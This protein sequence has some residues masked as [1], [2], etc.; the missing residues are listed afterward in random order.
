MDD[1][2]SAQGRRDY[3]LTVNGWVVQ[4]ATE[5]EKP[6][7]EEAR[8]LGAD[9]AA[10]HPAAAGDEGVYAE[11]EAVYRESEQAR[12]R[13]GLVG[14][15]VDGVMTPEAAVFEAAWIVGALRQR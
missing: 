14:P 4:A 8:R 9:W 5:A 15:E 13:R 10:K 1:T 11:L 7:V 3:E 6:L 2:M 12:K